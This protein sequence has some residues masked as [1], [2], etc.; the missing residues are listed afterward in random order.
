MM[1]GMTIAQLP[2]GPVIPVSDLDR[3]RAFYE[4]TLGLAGGPAPGGY[5]LHCGD[6]TV[7]YLLP[8]TDYPG[9]AAWPI[10]SFAATDLAAVTAD[11]RERGVELV[12]FDEGPQRTDA[13]GI[14]DMGSLRIAWFC[15]PDD[16]IISVFEP[17]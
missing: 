11:L 3:A 6:G 4:D 8:S 1:T 7:I 15:D 12:A 17:G 5:R 13:R 14:A 9:R 2:V 16:N 10:A